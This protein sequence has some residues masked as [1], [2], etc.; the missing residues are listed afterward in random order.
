MLL[1]SLALVSFA[2]SWFMQGVLHPL[3]TPSHIVLVLGLGLLLGQQRLLLSS[4]LLFGI[5]L[6][7]GLILNQTTKLDLNIELILL[8]LGLLVSLLVIIKLPL[9]SLLILFLVIISGI[10][11]GLDSSPILI[12]GLGSTS[13][14]N[15]LLGAICSFIASTLI[16]TLIAYFINNYWQGIILRVL[17]SWIAT[18]TIFILTF[19]LV[20]Q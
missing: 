13:I 10:S 19:M 20:K 7:T 11:L 16:T 6:L 12:P 18:S 14:Y 15:W 3:Q 1:F 4:L 8:A 2:P 9:P 5:S 17:A